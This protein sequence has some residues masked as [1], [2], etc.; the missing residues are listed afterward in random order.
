[1]DYEKERFAETVGSTLEQIIKNAGKVANDDI[2]HVYFY[3]AY[4]KEL[5][6]PGIFGGYKIKR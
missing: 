6:A 4:G 1:M 5:A 3:D 2:V